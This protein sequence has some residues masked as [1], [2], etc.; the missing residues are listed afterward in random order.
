V[1]DTSTRPLSGPDTLGVGT[2][3]AA[4]GATSRLSISTMAL[5]CPSPKARPGAALTVASTMVS[6]TLPGW[7]CALPLIRSASPAA[8]RVTVTSMASTVNWAL[9][10]PAFW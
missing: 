4:A 7:A 1:P 9:L 3:R 10:A 6:F 5:T 8:A 2:N